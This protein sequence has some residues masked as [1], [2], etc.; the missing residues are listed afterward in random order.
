LRAA[1]KASKDPA[2]KANAEKMVTVSGQV[3]TP[4]GKPAAGADVALTAWPK[5]FQRRKDDLEM[6]FGVLAQGKADAKG[7]F[8]FRVPSP[9]HEPDPVT[10][11]AVR[12]AMLIAGG[13]G[14][15][16]DLQ[17]LKLD[18]DCKGL[19]VRLP[20]E[21]VL[22]GRLIDL[23]AAPVKGLKVRCFAV[24]KQPRTEGIGVIRPTKKLALWPGP[25][26]TDAKGRFVVRG[27]GEGQGAYLEIKDDRFAPVT[28][29]LAAGQGQPKEL[30]HILL[31][32]KQVVGR[33]TYA[34]TGKPVPRALIRLGNFQNPGSVLARTDKD[35]RYRI[36]PTG[37]SNLIAQPPAGEPYLGVIQSLPETKGAAQRRLDVRL[38]R[39]VLVRGRVTEAGSGKPVA[40]AVVY[41]MQQDYDNRDYRPGLALGWEYPVWTDRKG[42]FQMTVQPG[43]GTLLAKA[44][45]PDY[46]PVEIGEV[47]NFGGLTLPHSQRWSAHGVARVNFKPK[48]SPQTVN[49]QLRPG[50]TVTGKVVGPDGKPVRPYVMM[51]TR[52]N[53]SAAHHVHQMTPPDWP[54]EPPGFTL[55]SCDP[56]NPYPVIFFDEKNRCGAVVTISGKQKGK[57]LTVKLARCGTAVARFVGAD[58]KPL[59]DYFPWIYLLVSPGPHGYEL[60]K[61]R[62]H[63]GLP[64]DELLALHRQFYETEKTKTDAKG[65]FT[66]PLLIPGATYR[67]WDPRTTKV[68]VREFTAKPGEKKDLGDIVLKLADGPKWFLPPS[69]AASNKLGL[70]RNGN[71]IV[72][73]CR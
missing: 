28:L 9:V 14:Y 29:T 59:A 2:N 32:A 70:P 27:V 51:I 30:L 15:G 38:P 42:K 7:R 6:H 52:L 63:K 55:K 62:K 40:R 10:K 53:T 35:G 56:D 1:D 22:R 17:Y 20:K 69:W 13:K 72:I 48:R 44:R 12:P 45:T 31:P 18:A 3:L 26:V 73:A 64:A 49:F 61:V 4:E 34:D 36:N 21:L 60:D 67:I 54:V 50:V 37:E 57:P 65:R 11:V 16:F 68:L 58:G 19:V 25:L 46:I 41:F 8:Q 5:D 71:S 39:G 23:Q 24:M 43:P 33:V 47:T 66:F